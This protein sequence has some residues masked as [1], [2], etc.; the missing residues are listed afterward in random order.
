MRV[1]PAL[2]AIAPAV[3]A[4]TVVVASARPAAAQ[5]VEGLQALQRVV[6]GMGDFSG[7]SASVAMRLRV[8]SETG[9][10]GETPVERLLVRA[11]NRSVLDPSEWSAQEWAVLSG[12]PALQ[13]VLGEVLLLDEGTLLQLQHQRLSQSLQAGASRL[14]EDGCYGAP[15]GACFRLA[16]TMRELGMQRPVFGGPQTAPT[17]PVP[18]PYRMVVTEA[19]NEHELGL[20]LLERWKPESEDADGLAGLWRGTL[21]DGRSVFLTLD[22]AGNVTD[23]GQR[24]GPAFSWTLPARVV[25]NPSPTLDLAAEYDRALAEVNAIE[26]GLYRFPGQGHGGRRGVLVLGVTERV[27]QPPILHTRLGGRYG[28]RADFELQDDLHTWQVRPGGYARIRLR[29]QDGQMVFLQTARLDDIKDWDL[30]GLY[31][32]FGYELES[33]IWESAGPA[34]KAPPTDP[35]LQD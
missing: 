8:L 16:D 3:L 11:R 13:R 7:H 32:R 25:R 24:N 2:R 33:A 26:P 17:D 28:P 21:D 6:S 35:A 20:W 23:V 10:L 27:Q 1:S 19:G 15:V 22:E 4:V 31:Q 29:I 34:V 18:G 14:I 5:S 9:V 30:S 12:D